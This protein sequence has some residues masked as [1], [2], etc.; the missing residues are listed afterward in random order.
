MINKPA[1]DKSDE[2]GLEKSFEG[3]THPFIPP[4]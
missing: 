3:C 1:E 4:S 2:V